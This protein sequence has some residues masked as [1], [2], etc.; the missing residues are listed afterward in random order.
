MST[1]PVQLDDKNNSSISKIMEMIDL[2]TALSN[3]LWAVVTH[4]LV[5]VNLGVKTFKSFSDGFSKF[6]T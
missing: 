3:G 6:Q 2:N 1:A 5:K 4:T